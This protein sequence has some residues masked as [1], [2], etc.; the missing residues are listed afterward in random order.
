MTQHRFNLTRW[1]LFALVAMS[2]FMLDETFGYDENAQGILFQALLLEKIRP[3]DMLVGVVVGWSFVEYS[4]LFLTG[5]IFRRI[6]MSKW[7]VAT[8][9]AIIFALVV[10]VCGP[11]EN[12]SLLG[13]HIWKNLVLGVG[14]FYAMFCCLRDRRALRSFCWLL[15]FCGG[16]FSLFTLG[17]Y[18]L[19]A[20]GVDFWFLGQVT[21][22]EGGQ[23]G[24]LTLSSLIAIGLLF[25]ESKRSWRQVLL[26]V[27]SV[28]MLL[29]IFFS[30]R[31][32][33]WGIIVVGLAGMFLTINR[34]AKARILVAAG[35][36]IVVA[37]LML[38]LMESNQWFMRLSVRME[39]LNPFVTVHENEFAGTNQFHLD[40][41]LDTWQAIWQS[42]VRGI[43]FRRRIPRWRLFRYSEVLEVVH[44]EFLGTWL[45][46]GLLGAIAYVGMYGCAIRQGLRKLWKMPQ[47]WERCVVGAA[48]SFVIARL[49]CSV[50][51]PPF[52]TAFKKSLAVFICFA[53][54]SI[55][56]LDPIKDFSNRKKPLAGRL[57][58]RD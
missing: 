52:Y 14:L 54:I 39:S 10:S 49:V 30:L 3:V 26:I 29:T 13:L 40:D 21:V 46:F 4:S 15:V 53:L 41:V 2:Y 38:P 56:A 36:V 51:A 32:S 1:A 20:G 23:L 27:A 35:A 22:V 6:P 55:L 50:F 31:R 7:F 24:L 11:R 58:G 42:P 19:E 43:G 12:E 8:G 16:I 18:S 37:M 28:A 34:H 45:V 47:E 57:A 25:S 48:V 5:W 9:V 17:A 33:A 44:S